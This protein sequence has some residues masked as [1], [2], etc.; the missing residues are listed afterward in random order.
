VQ[1]LKNAVIGSSHCHCSPGQFE[2]AARLRHVLCHLAVVLRHPDVDDPFAV[3]PERLLFVVDC[4]GPPGGPTRA[5]TRANLLQ[6]A[7]SNGE[8]HANGSSGIIKG[9]SPQNVAGKYVVVWEK[10]GTE[11]KNTSDIWNMDK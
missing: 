5:S 11:W 1:R 6:N 3:S 9:Q 4:D 10:V 7:P 2:V 8:N